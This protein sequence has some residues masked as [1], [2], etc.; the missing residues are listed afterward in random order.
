M[1]WL[2]YIESLDFALFC[3]VRK[4]APHLGGLGWSCARTRWRHCGES[5]KSSFSVPRLRC[6]VGNYAPEHPCTPLLCMLFPPKKSKYRISEIL[7]LHNLYNRHQVLENYTL[8]A[9]AW[10]EIL[11]LPFFLKEVC[12]LANWPFLHSLENR[13]AAPLTQIV[14]PCSISFVR[15]PVSRPSRVQRPGRNTFCRDD[16]YCLECSRNQTLAHLGSTLLN[17]FAA[18]CDEKKK[19]WD[20]TKRCCVS[21]S[22]YYDITCWDKSFLINPP[23]IVR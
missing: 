18:S 16:R 9:S 7:P 14:P 22:W 11:I 12:K 21:I 17:S 3:T 1:N 8:L 20:R 19:G 15:W 23:H 5:R 2:K 6:I 13:Q 10:I 4:S